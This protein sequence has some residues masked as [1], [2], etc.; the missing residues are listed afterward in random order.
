MKRINLFM[1]EPQITAMKAMASRRDMSMSDI[2]RRAVDQYL[3]EQT[4]CQL[5]IKRNHDAK[6]AKK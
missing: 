5:L 6:L 4:P 2:I 1:S 3:T